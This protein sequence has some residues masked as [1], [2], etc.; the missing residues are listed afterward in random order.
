MIAMLNYINKFLLYIVIAGLLCVV[1]PSDFSAEASDYPQVRVT[2]SNLNLR[3]GP[4]TQYWSLEMLRQG[5]LLSVLANDNNWMLVR[6][7]DGSTGWVL[8]VF[9]SNSA[10]LGPISLTGQGTGS[11]TVPNLNI[12][13]G[14]GTNYRSFDRLPTGTPVRI[15]KEENNWSLI[16]LNYGSAGWVSSGLVSGDNGRESSTPGSVPAGNNIRV[17]TDGLN[18]RIGPGARYWSQERLSRG[19]ELTVLAGENGWLL[20]RK[21]GGTTGWVAGSHTSNPAAVGSLSLQGSRTVWTSIAGLNIRSGPGTAFSGF[22][23]LPPGTELRV[24]TEA[25]G[26]LLVRLSYG[27][28]G[29]VWGGFTG[30]ERVELPSRGAETGN[31]LRGRVIAV[32]AGHG[33]SNPGAVGVTGLREKVVVLKTSEML[34]RYLRAQGARVVMTRSGDYDVSLAQRVNITHNQGAHIFIS[35][36]ANWHPNPAISGTETYYYNAGNNAWSSRRLATL[37]QQEMV[38]DSGLRNIGVKHGNFHVIR[39]TRV[40]AVLAEIGFL[41]NYYDESLMKKDSFLDGQARAMSRAI[42][43]YFNN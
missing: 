2:A 35:I 22:D 36:H 26:W 19:S 6:K 32:D 5:T 42:I 39:N 13:T 34:A 4:G 8:G 10:A 17:S 1:L 43:A 33:G 27:S 31:L 24:L 21:P 29:W 14:P 25:Q 3:V 7:A 30:S 16:R 18:F 37:V 15:L 41:S 40:P 11:T 9:T 23:R 28:T 12:R 20:T 38:R